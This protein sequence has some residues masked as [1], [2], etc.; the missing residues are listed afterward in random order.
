MRFLNRLQTSSRR[1]SS[2][3]D[4]VA[5]LLHLTLGGVLDLASRVGLGALGL[6]GREVL[7]ELLRALV[8]LGVT[9]GLETLA[10]QV[11]LRLER[12]QVAVTRVLVDR[13]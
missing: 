13:R 1:S 9:T 11:D 5:D 3:C 10:L 6:E 7:L 2:R 12:G 8:D 4:A